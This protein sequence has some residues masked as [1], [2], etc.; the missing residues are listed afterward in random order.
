MRGGRLRTDEVTVGS[1]IAV[2]DI[3]DCLVAGRTALVD[4]AG[5]FRTRA[6]VTADVVS[7]LTLGRLDNL[8]ARLCVESR[9]DILV[10]RES[11]KRPRSLEPGSSLFMRFILCPSLFGV[12]MTMIVLLFIFVATFG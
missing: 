2:S 7:V 1:E 3:L 4:L 10:G 8:V 12:G 9:K 11:P 5:S 6:S